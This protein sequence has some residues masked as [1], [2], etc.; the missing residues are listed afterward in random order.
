MDVKD[1]KDTKDT[2]VAEVAEDTKVAGVGVL[3]FFRAKR[4]G[5]KFRSLHTNH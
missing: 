2:E 4:F 5:E 3:S 1:T